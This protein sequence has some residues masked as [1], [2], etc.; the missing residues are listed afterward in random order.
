MSN[1][2]FKV[3]D[4]CTWESF[5]CDGMLSSE[6][7][8]NKYGEPVEIV[9]VQDVPTGDEPDENGRTER[10][11]VGHHQFVWIKTKRGTRKMSGAWFKKI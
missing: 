2:T 7:R 4:F 10:S 6:W 3:G 9:R 1:D 11:S 8:K 5:V